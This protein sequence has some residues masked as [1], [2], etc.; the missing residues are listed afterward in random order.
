[1]TLAV[2]M[3]STITSLMLV[4]GVAFVAVVRG[5]STAGD[6]VGRLRRR[7]DR[8]N[9]IMH[10]ISQVL[11]IEIAHE[12]YVLHSLANSPVGPNSVF[13]VLD[14]IEQ[15]FTSPPTQYRL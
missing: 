12:K 8:P 6:T 9:F 7:S 13:V 5:I 1:M 15:C 3:R 14:W 11:H 10:M 4:Y 2:N